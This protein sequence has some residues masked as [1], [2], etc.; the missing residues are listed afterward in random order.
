MPGHFL[1]AKQRMTF[2]CARGRTCM[3]VSNCKNESR[4]CLIFLGN[5]FIEKKQQKQ[6]ALRSAIIRMVEMLRFHQHVHQQ[7]IPRYYPNHR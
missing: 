7:Q 5:L 6:E 1:N 4:E 3:N 2:L